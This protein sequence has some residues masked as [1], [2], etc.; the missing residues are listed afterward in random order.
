MNPM[1]VKGG[2]LLQQ[3]FER[4]FFQESRASQ[5]VL[6]HFINAVLAES[7]PSPVEHIMSQQRQKSYLL[8]DLQLGLD[9]KARTRTEESVEIR[10]QVHQQ[11][12]FQSQSSALTF[13]HNNEPTEVNSR[14]TRFSIHLLNFNLLQECSHYHNCYQTIRSPQIGPQQKIEIHYL[15]LLKLTN[16]E[17]KSTLE[18][19]LYFISYVGRKHTPDS[20]HHLIKRD[21][22]F[23]LANHLYQRTRL[24]AKDPIVVKED[25]LSLEKW[26]EHG[27][28]LEKERIAMNMIKAGFSTQQIINLTDLT[29]QELD[30][31]ALVI[32][33]L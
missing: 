18:K 12:Y 2:I 6:L 21:P 19:W 31:L 28:L 17:P 26:E 7:L 16:Q 3:V 22:Y 11:D 29:M 32:P 23:K 24:T 8:R 13:N 27:Q 33:L 10:I 4:V 9:V 25:Q 20:F 14:I 30:D 1:E 5:V 15:E